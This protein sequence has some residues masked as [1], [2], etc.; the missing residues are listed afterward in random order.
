[1]SQQDVQADEPSLDNSFVMETHSAPAPSLDIPDEIVSPQSKSVDH[2]ENVITD[3]VVQQ[4]D[5]V[6]SAGTI[7]ITSPILPI[8]MEISENSMNES[9]NQSMLP[10][11]N[12]MI[13]MDESVAMDVSTELTTTPTSAHTSIDKSIGLISPTTPSVPKE[14]KKRIIIDDDDESPTFN[15]LRSTKKSRSKNR[16]KQLLLKKQQQKA[17]LLSP[18]SSVLGDKANENAV[19]T[20]PEGIVSIRFRS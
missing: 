2:L 5:L 17:Q 12:E 1:M 6:T 11:P 14:R 19:F 13:Q 16:R 4:T 8:P 18:S 7:T 10:L 15:P 20:S 3:T 9:P